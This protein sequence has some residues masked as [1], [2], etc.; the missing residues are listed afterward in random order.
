MTDTAY[1]GLDSSSFKPLHLQTTPLQGDLV[2]SAWGEKPSAALKGWGW[3]NVHTGHTGQATA[4]AAFMLH[5]G[6][7]LINKHQIYESEKLFHTYDK[8]ALLILRGI[9]SSINNNSNNELVLLY[10]ILIWIS[11]L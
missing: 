8:C 4:H 7:L 3:S 10:L 2:D 9:I 6:C 11:E 1:P 5:V